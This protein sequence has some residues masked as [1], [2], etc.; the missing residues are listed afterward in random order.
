MQYFLLMAV[1][2]PFEQLIGETLDNERI[3]AYFLTE[4][5]HE[6]LKVIVQMLERQ[7]Q[8][9]IRVDDLLQAYNIDMAELFEDGNLTNGSRGNSL[10]LGLESYLL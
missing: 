10:L 6:L 5:P 8:F 7:D 3:H 1:G 4:I 9:S 2:D